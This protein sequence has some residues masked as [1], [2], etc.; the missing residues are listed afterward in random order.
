MNIQDNPMMTKLTHTA[1]QIMPKG[2]KVWLYGSRARGTATESS[3]WDLLLLVD[4]P[5][6]ETNDFNDYAYPFVLMGWDV[7]A[8]VSPQLYTFSEW[9]EREISPY[10]QNVERDKVVI[11]ES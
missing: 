1:T 9:K 11:Y 10:Y 8:D 2:S 4:K 6:I 7:G 3:D 5:M